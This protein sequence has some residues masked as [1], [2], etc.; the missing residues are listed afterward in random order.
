MMD[1][2]GQEGKKYSKYH[3]EGTVWE[4]FDVDIQEVTEIGQRATTMVKE[5]A[6]EERTMVF[7]NAR[8]SQ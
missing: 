6:Q 3:F 2:K 8:R 7:D 1:H 5:A 4:R